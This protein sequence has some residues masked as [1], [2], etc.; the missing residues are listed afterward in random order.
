LN[1]IYH[2]DPIVKLREI[3]KK[4]EGYRILPEFDFLKKNAPQPNISV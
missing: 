3:Y 1:V 4:K 2:F